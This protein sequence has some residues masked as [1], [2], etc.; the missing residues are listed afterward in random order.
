MQSSPLETF[1]AAL[2]TVNQLK[3]EPTVQEWLDAEG[4]RMV[5]ASA[6]RRADQYMAQYPCITQADID[7][8]M[9]GQDDNSYG[10]N[11]AIIMSSDDKTARRGLVKDAQR[12]ECVFTRVHLLPHETTHLWGGGAREMVMASWGRGGGGEGATG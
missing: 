3:S 1:Q 7:W 8:L 11:K 9:A 5:Q 12:G 2:A 6:Q 10:H 4:A